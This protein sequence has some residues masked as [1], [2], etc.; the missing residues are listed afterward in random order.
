MNGRKNTKPRRYRKSR[1]YISKRKAVRKQKKSNFTRAV[2]KVISTIAEDKMA[3]FNFTPTDTLTLFNSGIS[4]AAD[5][6]Q[7]IPN[8][9]QGTGD[10]N[11]LGDQ[12]RVKNL[13]IKGY[14][15]LSPKVQSSS[16]TNEPKI[17]NVMV[18]L[19]V[20]SLKSLSS[21]PAAVNQ[22]GYLTSLLKKGASTVAY[23]GLLSD[24][25]CPINS[26]VFTTHH[27]QTFYLTQDYVFQPTTTAGL[28]GPTNVSI[29][30][31][32]KFFNINLKCKDRIVKYDS[33]NG[34]IQPTKESMELI[35]PDNYIEELPEIHLKGLQNA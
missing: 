3:Y 24:N 1:A 6:C 5:M 35:D 34:G 4:G 25:F 31:T 26:E 33:V 14:V 11:R 16:F 30:D 27:D 20:V 32:I 15:R 13:N 7:V 8:I 29:K 12:I 22:P 18:R 17:S 9:S 23:T 28:T 21:Y 10:S 2:K 19:M